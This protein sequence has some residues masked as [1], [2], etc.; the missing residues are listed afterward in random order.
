M[1]QSQ[2]TA[3]PQPS[4]DDTERERFIAAIE[5]GLADVRAGRVH[6]HAEVVAEMRR[7]F[8]PPK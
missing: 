5:A 8:P 2:P 6:S 1:P 7:R 4:S 3:Q